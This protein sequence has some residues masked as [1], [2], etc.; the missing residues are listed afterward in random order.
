M[1]IVSDA[2]RSAW[3]KAYL[4]AMLLSNIRPF[5]VKAAQQKTKE[6]LQNMLRSRFAKLSKEDIDA[7]ES[8]KAY[9]AYYK[10]FEYSFDIRVQFEQL[11]MQEKSK[12]LMHPIME[13]VF[14]ASLDN[15]ILTTCHDRDL[16]QTPLSLAVADPEQR[17]TNRAGKEQIAVAGDMTVS[18]SSGIITSALYG[19]G[20]QI[21]VRNDT[22]RILVLA[23]A[24]PGLSYSRLCS[25]FFLIHSL[26][27]RFAPESEINY[28]E[29]VQAKQ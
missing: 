26:I 5:T 21:P 9:T 19:A 23:F 20:E 18:D 8:V 29:L 4:G 3:P 12:A 22:K 7:F 25:H 13:A 15:L 11:L 16:V 14:R 28:F 17:F 2:W 1:F 27:R 6:E 10:R 24:P